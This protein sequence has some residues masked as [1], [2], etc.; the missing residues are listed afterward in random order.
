MNP[1]QTTAKPTLESEE[2]EEGKVVDGLGG[3]ADMFEEAEVVVGPEGV[4][5]IGHDVGECERDVSACN[6]LL[7]LA[8]L[9]RKLFGA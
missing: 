4:V 2:D 3:V 8:R 1:S 5:V 6:N 9:V 7:G